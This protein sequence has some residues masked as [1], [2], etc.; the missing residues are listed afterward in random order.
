MGKIY[1]DTL[2]VLKLKTP[3]HWYI[4]TTNR[5]FESRMAEH[6][7]GRGSVWTGRHGVD[8]VHRVWRIPL[9][10]STS[11]MENEV[12]LFYMRHVAK[13]WRNVKGGDYTWSKPF[14]IDNPWENF[15]IPEEFGGTRV[16]DY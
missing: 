8:R 3:D 14:D 5:I 4:G 7:E 16:V 1:R 13:D 6:L 9:D 11:R 12:T 10:Y 15:W 2:Y